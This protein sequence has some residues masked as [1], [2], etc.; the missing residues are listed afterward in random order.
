MADIQSNIQVNIDTSDALAS[1]KLLQKQISAFHNQMAKGG[2][3]ANAVAGNLQ[4]NLINS[5]NATGKFSAEMRTVKTTTESFTN[6]LEKNKLSMR[7]YFRFSAAST[8][9]FGRL[10]RSEFETINKVARERVKDLQT[11]YIKM[12]RDANGALK[13]IAV[14]PLALDMDNLATKT[15][16]A[17]QRQALLNQMLKQGSTNLLNFGKNTQ[18]AGRQ[19][20]VGFTIPLTMLGTTAAKTFM[21]M[22]E[23]AIRFKRVYG[24]TFTATEETDRML[25]QIKELGKEFTKYGVSV[26][27]TMSMAAD[28]AAMGKQGAD[29][30][31]QVNEATRLAILGGV[32]QEQALETTISLTNAFGTAAEDLAGKINFLNSVENQTVTSIEDLTIAI[33]KAGPVVQQLG[34]DVEDLAFFLTAMKEGG[35]NASEGA[36]ALK[37]GLAS[38]INPTDKAAKMLGG[39][40]INIKEI[41]NANKG[42]VKGIVIDFA[43]ALDQLDPLNRAQAIEQLFGKFQFARL[44]T[45]FQNVIKEGS[46]ASRVLEMTNATTEELAILAERELKRVEDS[47]MY[48]FKAAVEELK[49]SLVPLGEAFVKAVTPLIEF[50]TKVLDKFNGMSD[51]AKSFLVG[52]TGIAGVIA[53]AFL[54][55]FGLVAN[56]VANLI[57]LF[58]SVKGVYN[59]LSGSSTTL[60]QTTDYMTQ[61]QLEAAAVAAS[62]E[63]AHMRLS[64]AFSSEKSALEALTT[65]YSKAIAVQAQYSGAAIPGRGKPMKKYNDGVFM[66]PGTGNKDTVAAMLTPGEAVV[67]KEMVKKYGPLIQGMIAG[68]LPGYVDGFMP[69]GMGKGYKNATVYLPE[70]M[71]TAMGGA[72]QGA[73]MAQVTE[74]LKRAGGAAM[75][76]LMTVMARE[77]GMKIND[78]RFIAEFQKLGS[79]LSTNAIAAL[80]KSGKQFITD[81]DFEE[82]VVPAMRKTTQEV[83]VAGKNMAQAFE[84]AVTQI[85]TVGPV[86]TQS[87]SKSGAG[88]VAF[89]GSYKSDAVRKQSQAF[90]MATNPTMFQRVARFSQ[91]RGK[92]INEFRTPNINTGQLEIA[93]AAHITKSV[94]DSVNN[95]IARMKPILGDIGAR[96]V[97][98][99]SKGIADAAAKEARVAS[100]S[101]ET[102]RVGKEIGR[103][104]VIGVQEYVDDAKNAGRQ[105][106]TAVVSGVSEK[107]TQ[108]RAMLYGS[109]PVDSGA[110]S[111]RRQ[112]QKQAKLQQIEEKRAYQ[113]SVVTAQLAGAT[114]DLRETTKRLT[115]RDK[116][117]GAVG[118]M[119]VGGAGMAASGVVMAASMVPGKVGETAQNLMMPMIA[120][121]TILPLL[122]NPIMAAVAAFA[123]VGV[124]AWMMNERLKQAT[125]EGRKLGESM[126]MTKDK[127]IEMSKITGQVSA[128]ELRAKKQENQLTGESGKTRKF[129][130]TYLESES[131]KQMVSDIGTMKESGMSD[132]QVASVIS[133]NL[134]LA[135]MQGVVTPEQA[136][137]IAAGLGQEL[138]N[139]QISAQ[140]SGDLVSLFGRDGTNL[141][142]NP[143]KVAVEL[144]QQ[145]QTAQQ[146]VFDAAQSGQLPTRTP[147]T[148]ARMGAG[149]G[150][151]ASGMLTTI[152]T[153]WTGVGL[154]AGLGQ[155]A[156]GVVAMASA[157]WEQNEAIA[158]NN[159]LNAAAIQLGFEQI[160]TNQGI[161]DSTAQAYDQKIK[162]AEANLAN[163]KTAEERKT[164]EKELNDIII[165]RDSAL[166]KLNTENANYIQQLT[167]QKSLVGADT[168]QTSVN[169]SLDAMKENASEPMKVFIDQAKKDLEGLAESDF[170]T[171]LQVG[172]A[173]GQLDP[174]AVS[175]LIDA[176]AN[177]ED[178]QAD[179]NLLIK[180]QGVASF[181]QVTQLL[182]KAGLSGDKMNIIFDLIAND[183]T[184][185]ENNTEA[186]AQ[187]ANMQQEYGFKINLEGDAG[188]DKVKELSSFI[189][190]TEELPDVVNKQVLT[191]FL[192]ANPN[193]PA[194]NQIRDMID[195]W[196]VLSGGKKNIDKAITV[197]FVAAGDQNVLNAYLAS[198]GQSGLSAYLS[199]E[200]LQGTYGARAQA[201]AVGGQGKDDPD[202]KK[203]NQN[204]NT[205]TGGKK[206]D[207]YEDVLKSLKR[208]R[209]ASINAAGGA[210]ELKRV[211]GGSKDIKIFAGMEQ[212]LASMNSQFSEYLVG[213]DDKTRKTFVT[214]KNGKAVLTDLGKAM[215]KA[216]DEKVLGDFQ[217]KQI[218][219]TATIGN[220]NAAFARLTKAGFDAESAYDAVADSAFAAAVANKK[221]TDAELKKIAKAWEE[222]KKKKDNYDRIRAIR[223]ENADYEKQVQ[224]LQKLESVAGKYSQEQISSILG[225]EN[226]MNQFLANP[227][228]TDFVKNMQN[229]LDKEQFDLRVKMLTIEGQEE[230]FQDG[231]SKAMEAFAAQEQK[232]EI[233]FKIKNKDDLDAVAKAED[234]IAKLQYKIDDWEA[235]LKDIEKQEEAINDSYETKFSA[236]DKIQKANDNIS[237]QQKAQLT[238]ADAL[239]QGDI[240]AAAKAAQDMRAQAA[241]DSISAQRDSLTQA[242]D[243]ELANV[244]N[245][246]GYTREQIETSIRDLQDEIFEIEEKTLEPARERL[247]IAELEKQ[248]AIEGLEVLGKTKFQ[249]EQIKNEIDLAKT[250]SEKY[251][252]AIQRALDVVKGIV[253][254]WNGLNGKVVNTTHVIT[255]VHKTVTEG[256]APDPNNI[257]TNSSLAQAN[258]DYFQ[259]Q[260]LPAVNDGTATASQ[261]IDYANAVNQALGR[262][263]GTPVA[264]SK[265][266]M[267]PKMSYFLNGGFARGT[268]TVPAMLTPGEF[269]VS[270]FAVK[271][272]GVDRLKAINSGA[273]QNESVYNNYSVTVNAKS[274]ANPDDIAN[275][276]MTQIKQ[277]D[278]RR[279]R[280]V[281]L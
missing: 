40:G 178:M 59:R 162:E 47:P 224:V 32:E 75:A 171:T 258:A 62:L 9:T 139:Y 236:L 87:G 102:Q 61:Q 100:P 279:L 14:R 225:N 88:R 233:D 215:R 19:L 53:P 136:R 109:G 247:R 263:Q 17:A 116:I 13:A 119:G 148:D 177:N 227:N 250:N 163:A 42:D 43:E 204:T 202:K 55:T 31:A 190:A 186:L 260:V 249:W 89:A 251:K 257:M 74:Y 255:T 98:A 208:V 230:I 54:M 158:Q 4:Q 94:T 105:V 212:S 267:V 95:L 201:W 117:S 20:M 213:L 38:L 185:F 120:L 155:V 34:G 126:S 161:L 219:T 140:I 12:G 85:R 131:G 125:E 211:L 3:A 24:D 226:L 113:A 271:D 238:L 176:G 159:K 49:V 76:P 51:G 216:Y 107:A 25:A 276:V 130:Q 197:D 261:V 11:Q 145:G 37:S 82:L 58:T 173:S 39:F 164:A 203:N 30:L 146:Q 179:M 268:D 243:N 269:V 228:N 222:A 198:I 70:S 152:A 45:L 248:K 41:V 129:G 123:A 206:E 241:A 16:I 138:G 71:N 114:S 168:F 172:I 214:F 143:L 65:A 124:A 153:G 259:N 52:L 83:N 48:K 232:I 151:V 35:I 2:A 46:Q 253:D 99:T 235:G 29:L 174:I 183:P 187:L 239:S 244:R 6:A 270:K 157:L 272:F 221:L 60:G 252:E 194:S 167:D 229:L 67:P 57:K 181:N 264:M 26:E 280:G 246:L 28:A 18:W 180:E 237:R 265:G 110:K 274:D 207:P 218:Q 223:S 278:S 84:N 142:E 165:E 121:Q 135:I 210:K 234:D 33:P 21:Q 256:G 182:L 115:L 78:P 188:A 245:S 195:N 50:G 112:M 132:S 91:S 5:I 205:D 128:T 147:G 193:S 96:V 231:F 166:K 200:I 175:S 79:A 108:S 240:A 156:V 217:L 90:A 262:P 189:T 23:Q 56:G 63:Q 277:I 101:K 134:S 66:V 122:K 86:G 93:T 144:Q 281:R 149:V 8:K 150:L 111:M 242:K 81:S 141:L 104:A 192:E 1:I 191:D 199:P 154:V 170:K 118:R 196:D 137:S 103:G 133:R 92:T 184:N 72:G 127:L 80:E 68:N 209:D 44:S 64:Q 169:A 69:K 273:Y 220:Q 160:A 266:G 36:N 15:A 97:K 275:A 106:G 254:Y 77:M 22:E 7:E 27:Q 73:A 10:F